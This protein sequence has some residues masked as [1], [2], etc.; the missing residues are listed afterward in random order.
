MTTISARRVLLPVGPGSGLVSD[1]AIDLDE[2]G[3]IT[4]VRPM[5]SGDPEPLDGLV[6]PGLVNAHLHLELSNLAGRVRGGFGLPL[7]VRTLIAQRAEGTAEELQAAMVAAARSMVDAGVVAV[8]DVANG[9][10][11]AAVLAAMGLQGVVQREVLGMDARALPERL[12][13]ALQPDEE[14]LGERGHIAI[15]TSPHAT[16][17]TAPT[18]IRAAVLGRQER[19]FERSITETDHKRRSSARPPATIHCSED[20]EELVFIRSGA[21]AWSKL[22][23]QMG[24]DW[25]WF[26]APGCSP[27][28]YLESLDVLGPDLLVV[29]GVHLSNK[30]R[31]LLVRRGSTLVL[32]PRSNL[33]ITGDLPDL[34]SLIDEGVALA[35]GTDS[36][37]SCPDLDPLGCVHALADAFPAVEVEHLLHAATAGGSDA[38]RLAHLGRIAIGKAPGLVLLSGVDDASALRAGVPERRV[39][40]AAGEPA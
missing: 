15:R 38:L 7:W 14:I 17:S 11:T 35:I 36:L 6:I 5:R 28:E 2:T 18:L 34:P 23:D 4:D 39:L 26:Q 25:R 29:H 13:Q 21:G 32:C 9:D 27:V 40:V 30:D 33:H 3:T 12:Q 37:A 31:H 22:L 19:E 10:G 1:V 24:L 20:R 8:C 16:Y